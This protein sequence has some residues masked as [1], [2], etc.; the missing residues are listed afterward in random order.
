MGE[1]KR[2]HY[3]GFIL[4]YDGTIEYDTMSGGPTTQG[5]ILCDIPRANYP[6]L[7]DYEGDS[8]KDLF[9]QFFN[10]I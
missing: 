6:K 8:I 3:N 2:M 1:I 9:D 7:F 10:L 5:T 4:E